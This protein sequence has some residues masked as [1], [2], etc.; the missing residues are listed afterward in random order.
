MR[1]SGFSFGVLVVLSLFSGVSASAQ[2]HEVGL[3]IGGMS[4]GDKDFNLPSPGQFRIGTGLTYQANYAR[5]LVD[6][7]LAA[8]YVEFPLAATPSTEIN[9]S[10]VFAPRNYASLFITPGLKVKLLP[11]AGFSPYGF[12]GAGYARFSASSTLINGQ[13]N[14]GDRGTNRG[15]LDFGGGIDVKVFPYISLRGEVRDFYTGTPQLNVNLIENKQHNVVVS[16]GVVFR[17]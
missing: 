6:A 3:L 7:K 17:F 8:L 5:R 10:N 9:S 15:A 11:G 1:L 14:S 13:P 4:T 2:K 16:G 12:I